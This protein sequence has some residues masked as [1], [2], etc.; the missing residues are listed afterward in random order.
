M[1][2]I[3]DTNYEHYKK[4]FTVICRFIMKDSPSLLESDFSPIKVMDE[5]EKKDR[6]MAKKGLKHGLLDCLSQLKTE[7]SEKDK[8][9]LHAKL[10]GE[11]LPGLWELMAIVKDVQAKV[12]KRGKISNLDEWYVITELLSAVDSAISEDERTKL[13][14]YA[15][16]FET[17]QRRM[18]N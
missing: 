12:L 10:L 4:V 7:I 5:W 8:L 13:G 9:Q 3:T 15:S 18:G 1:L 11:G 2:K 6:A 16:A 14:E 17:R